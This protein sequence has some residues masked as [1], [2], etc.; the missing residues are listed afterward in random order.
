MES[1]YPKTLDADIIL[2]YV[3]ELKQVLGQASFFHQKTFLRPFVK[4]IEVNLRT[5]ALNFPIPLP[6]KKNRTSSREVL[7]INRDASGG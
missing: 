2:S 5:V 4:R 6:L 1:K 7:Y 3:K